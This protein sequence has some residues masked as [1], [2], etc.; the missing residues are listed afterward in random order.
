MGQVYIV[1]EEFDKNGFD[2]FCFFDNSFF[3]IWDMFCVFCLLSDWS[4][5]N[6]FCSIVGWYIVVL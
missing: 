4:G 2:V 5:G 6:M 1:L 3:D